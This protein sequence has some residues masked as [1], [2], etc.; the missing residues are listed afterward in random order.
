MSFGIGSLVAWQMQTLRAILKDEAAGGI[1]TI[2]AID[3]ETVTLEVL[4]I[5]T[6]QL[7]RV[8]FKLSDVTLRPI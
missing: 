2:V 8:T 3:D 5:G 4:Q 7:Q 6:H 1:G